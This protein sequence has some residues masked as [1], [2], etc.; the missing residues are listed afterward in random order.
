MFK[1]YEMIGN[2]SHEVFTSDIWNE[3]QDYLTSR[4]WTYCAENGV[5][6]DDDT[7]EELFYSYFSIDEVD[8]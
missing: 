1:V 7:E 6:L 2:F 8:T 5:D 3:V 4:W